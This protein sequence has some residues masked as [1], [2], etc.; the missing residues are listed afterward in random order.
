VSVAAAQA[1]QAAKP[2]AQAKAEN[3]TSATAQ[4]RLAVLRYLHSIQG[5]KIVVGIENKHG[6]VPTEDSNRVAKIAGR[7]PGFWG[8]DF[9]FGQDAIDARPVITAEAIRQW[10]AGSLVGLMYH[11]CPPTRD[12]LCDWDDIGGKT[13]SHLTDEQWDS[14][15]TP[16]TALNKEWYRRLD[17]IAVYLQQLKATGVVVLFR[18]FHEIN[19]CVFWWGCHPGPNG[20]VSLYRLTHDYLTKEKGLDNIIWVWSVQDFPTLETDVHKLDPGPGYYDIVTLDV[21]D[22]AGYT[23]ANYDTV[24]KAADGKPIAL[25]ECEHLP[26]LEMIARQP[27][28]TYVMLWP[29]FIQENASELPSLYAAPNIITLDRMTGWH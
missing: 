8:A 9:G 18:P 5:K 21:Y 15:L 17:N 16:G 10:K 22:K 2:D 20:A 14:L 12:E 1:I 23:Q 7:M 26:T 27:Q 11:A 25:A 24:L 28:W 13:P 4:S 6:G 3:P 29:D 19:Q